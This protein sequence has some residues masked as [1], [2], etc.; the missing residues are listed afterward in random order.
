MTITNHAQ[1]VFDPAKLQYNRRWDQEQLIKA[2]A[3]MS[4]FQRVNP[5]QAGPA[6]LGILLPPGGRTLVLLRPRSLDWDLVPLR[7]YE[8]EGS[9]T[10]FW[11]VARDEGASLASELHRGLEEWARGGLGRVE[12]MPA[13]GGKGYQVRVGLGRFVLIACDR[14]PGVP[15]KPAKFDTV[16]EA[17]DAAERITSVLCPRPGTNQEIYF[18]TDNFHK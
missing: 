18:N 8:I 11:E 2:K 9:Q 6:A 1:L 12:P 15:Y 5:S 17:L 14:V 10:P 13:P 16:S 3:K 4:R 7:P